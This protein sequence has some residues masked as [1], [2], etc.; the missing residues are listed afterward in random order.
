MTEH[1]RENDLHGD[2]AAATGVKVVRAQGRRAGL[3]IEEQMRSEGLSPH[4]WSNGS[5]YRYDTHSHP[6]HK[7]L[8]CVSGS[9][10]FH[11]GEGSVELAP[12]DRLE[13]DRGVDH[14][15][16]VGDAGVECMEAARY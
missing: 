15:A 9:I 16:T 8:Y 3:E 4:S 5:G 11:S 7:V 12:G 13:L 10:T 2:S 1:S 6:Y 14:G